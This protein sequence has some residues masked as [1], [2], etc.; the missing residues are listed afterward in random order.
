V[1]MSDLSDSLATTLTRRWRRRWCTRP[2]ECRA[3]DRWSA[4]DHS[5][6]TVT[7]AGLVVDG[8]HVRTDGISLAHFPLIGCPGTGRLLPLS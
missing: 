8:A 2:A 7:V 4:S 6:H 3:H 1:E 5:D